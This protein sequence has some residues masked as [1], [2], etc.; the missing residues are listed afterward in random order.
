LEVPRGRG[1][2]KPVEKVLFFSGIKIYT[3]NSYW[4]RAGASQKPRLEGELINF[5][6]AQ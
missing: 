5:D 3:G 6:T 4:G 1:H 2:Q